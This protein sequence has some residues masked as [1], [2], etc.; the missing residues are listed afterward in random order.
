MTIYELFLQFREVL[1]KQTSNNSP[2]VGEAYIELAFN[3]AIEKFVKERYGDA[4]RPRSAFEGTQK[5]MDDLSNLVQEAQIPP[6]GPYNYNFKGV[7]STLFP[8]PADYWI[9]VKEY[10]IGDLPPCPANRIELVC[11]VPTVVPNPPVRGPLRLF[12]RTHD[13]IH[14]L[15]EDPFNVPRLEEAHRLLMD[16]DSLTGSD[17]PGNNFAVVYHDA[18]VS[19]VEYRLTYIKEPKWLRHGTNWQL[20]NPTAPLFWQ[21]TEFWFN[22]ETHMELVRMAVA[23]V[24]N[25]HENPREQLYL[26]QQLS[27]QD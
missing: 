22:S 17:A 26:A 14:E 4:N 21:N 11:G 27:T 2:E 18:Q 3:R 16:G 15:L 8:I 12:V 13:Q 1:D 24:L 7:S 5:R 25:I 19:L 6:F 23:E 10:L 9:A 20:T